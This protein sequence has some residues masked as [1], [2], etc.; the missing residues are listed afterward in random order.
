MY[1]VAD[2]ADHNPRTLDGRNIF[3]GIVIIC[4]VTPAFSS[5]FAI[6]CLEDMSTEDLIIP[7]EMQQ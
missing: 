2:N 7:T 6:P 4:S 1:H 5:S 3:Y